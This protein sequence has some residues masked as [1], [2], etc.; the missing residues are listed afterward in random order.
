M[1]AW[2]VALQLLMLRNV[3]EMSLPA[4]NGVASLSVVLELA[5]FVPQGWQASE[6]L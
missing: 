5:C 6:T 2:L 4:G 3:R 1:A